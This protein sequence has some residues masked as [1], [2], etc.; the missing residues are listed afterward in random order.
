[1]DDASTDGTAAIVQSFFSSITDDSAASHD[2]DGDG[3]G[4]EKGEGEGDGEKG[5]GRAV[6]RLVRLPARRGVAGALNEVGMGVAFD[7]SVRIRAS[8]WGARLMVVYGYASLTY[9]NNMHVR[10]TVHTCVYPTHRA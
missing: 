7:G 10:V 3:Q 1:M 4:K 2:D 5:G 8:V 9:V 6:V